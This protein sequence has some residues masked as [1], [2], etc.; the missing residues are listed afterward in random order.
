MKEEAPENLHVPC[1]AL[2]PVDTAMTQRKTS[3]PL[4]AYIPEGDITINILN[5]YILWCPKK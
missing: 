1:I 3:G 2:S 5:K 4:G